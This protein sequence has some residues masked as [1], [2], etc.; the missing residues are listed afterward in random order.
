MS[1]AFD[2]TVSIFQNFLSIGKL[3]TTTTTN[4]NNVNGIHTYYT[5]FI[6]AFMHPYP[7]SDSSDVYNATAAVASIVGSS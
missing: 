1:G 3:P 2:L 5:I 6:T 7:Y 4:L